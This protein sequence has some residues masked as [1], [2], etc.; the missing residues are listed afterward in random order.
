VGK[1][2]G[3]NARLIARRISISDLVK[4]RPCR[5]LVCRLLDTFDKDLR[6]VSTLQH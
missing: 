6:D 5:P 2:A 1:C 3:A 4:K